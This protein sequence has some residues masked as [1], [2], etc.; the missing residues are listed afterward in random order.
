[1]GRLLFMI[2]ILIFVSLITIA[3]PCELF[4]TGARKGYGDGG[5]NIQIVGEPN[6]YV[7]QNTYTVKLISKHGRAFQK[8]KLYVETSS[9]E[10]I[11]LFN[12]ER[13][14]AGMFQLFPKDRLT[15]FDSDCT[16]TVSE[17]SNQDKTEIEAMWQAPSTGNG[18]VK[19]KANILANNQ[20][21]EASLPEM[22]E[23]TEHKAH[24]YLDCCACDEARY[25]FIFEGL[26]RNETHPKDFPKSLWLTHF[27]D[28]VGG[29]HGR[30]FSFWGEGQ[31]ASPGL[32][33]LAEWGATR[34]IDSELRSKSR[35]FRSLIKASGLWYPNVNANTSSNFRVDKRRNLLSLV[36]M[37]GPSPD[38][39][40]GVSSLNLCLQNCSWVESH[41]I[42][43]YPYDA[44]TDNG[45]SYMSLNIPAV[46][47]EKIHKITPMYPEDER[48]PFYDPV[49]NFMEPLA[50]LYITRDKLF[51]KSCDDK[52]V[53]ELIDEIWEVENSEEAL[54]KECA[55]TNYTEWSSCSVS[56]GKGLRMRNRTYVN[57]KEA[58]KAE[59]N[60]QLVSKEMC[61]A[62]NP[63]CPGDEEEG[64]VESK[65]CKVGEWEAWSDCSVSCGQGL[66]T[67][68]RRFP[69]KK[70]VKKCPHVELV[71]REPCIEPP[72]TESEQKVDPDCPVSPW[73][74]WSPCNATC[75]YGFKFHSRFSLASKEM[76][77]KCL[78]RAT[79]KESK[80]CKAP[81]GDCKVEMSEVKT[82]CML[83][84]ETG[85]C[86]AFYE[87]FRFEP[88]KG[89][90]IPFSYGG[91]RGNKNNFFTQEECLDFCKPIMNLLN[92]PAENTTSVP[93]VDCVLGEWSDWS[94]CSVQCGRGYKIKTRQVLVQAQGTGKPCP[95]VLTKRKICKGEQC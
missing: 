81:E 72:C 90:C 80:R 11:T 1:M 27:S 33:Q 92:D 57:P 4:S 53:S 16:N 74:D 93:N 52:S 73:S 82:I 12:N 51:K 46:P 49:N 66:K 10:N 6:K 20:L 40:V 18:C 2:W 43:L 79:L 89:M 50:R 34:I 59:C 69:D 8:F 17:A 58:I 60:R 36:S 5:F 87:R 94:N 91:C 55:V 28:V 88:M 56:C 25:K 68:I 61:I 54:R 62:A 70:S 63:Y 13:R 86:H 26:W 65:D 64:P 15:E 76:E 75:G 85:P 24:T 9:T 77:E 44:G 38:W 22:C 83:P 37:L 23:Y 21:F 42:N 31:I 7:A 71:Q 78:Q 35:Y 45:V 95:Q 41:I 32:K 67:R 84:E 48:A 14:S 3:S 47:Q 19:I 39:V 29:T 30:N